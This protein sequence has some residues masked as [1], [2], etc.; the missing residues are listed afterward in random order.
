ML[1]D[2]VLQI[3][4]CQYSL[5]ARH[6]V[7]AIEPR[8]VARRAIYRSPELELVTPRVL[9]HR[10]CAPSPQQ[11]VMTAVLDAGPGAALWGKSAACHWGFG[12]FRLLPPHIA[13][14]RSHPKGP[15]LGQIHLIGSLPSCDRTVHA[16]IPVARPE[17][18]VLWLAGMW[19]H[20]F[21]HEIA[22]ER[23]E[24]ALDQAWRQRLIDGHR[25]HELA[26]RSGGRGRSGIVVLRQA[27]E[28]RPPGYQPAG[29]RL[30]ER[31]ESI[32]SPAVAV[33]LARQVTVEVDPVIR[34]VDFRLSS[35]PLIAEINGEAFH[36]SLTDRGADGQ[37]YERLLSLGYSVVVFWEYDI[38]HDARTVRA[39]M[40][41]LHRNPD[42]E[43]TLH[44]PTKAPWAW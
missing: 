30:E 24:V 27:L 8:P 13:L 15:R 16:D 38:W 42:P 25:I 1:P 11:S 14:P 19:T 29:S 37:R 34:T 21:G 3:L 39:A 4:Q 22:L 9:R 7:Q 32:V 5:I 43:P 40:D 44:R 41:E 23:T 31:F 17:A 33:D 28:N 2:P 36:T 26:E 35:W 12:R 20:R 18:T 6:Q 10:A